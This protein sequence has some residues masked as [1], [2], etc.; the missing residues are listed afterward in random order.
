MKVLVSEIN[1]YEE[2]NEISK[3]LWQTVSILE[4]TLK[5]WC[6]SDEIIF[7]TWKQFQINESEIF[8]SN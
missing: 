1:V 8:L 6:L 2:T 5:S 7:N 4:W 3:N